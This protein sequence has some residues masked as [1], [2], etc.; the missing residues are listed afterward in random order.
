MVG[1]KISADDD[2]GNNPDMSTDIED[3]EE[4]GRTDGAYGTDGYNI[5]ADADGDST[6]NTREPIGGD[7]NVALPPEIGDDDPTR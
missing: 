4:G 6:S 5:D 3:M 7:A 1:N 2:Y